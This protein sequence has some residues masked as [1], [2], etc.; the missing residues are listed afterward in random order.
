[1]GKSSGHEKGREEGPLNCLN[2]YGGVEIHVGEIYL[3]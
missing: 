1:M 2:R 3:T